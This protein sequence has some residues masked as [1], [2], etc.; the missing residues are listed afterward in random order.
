MQN[1]S[2]LPT[3]ASEIDQLRQ[4]NWPGLAAK[5]P[6]VANEL[7]IANILLDRGRKWSWPCSRGAL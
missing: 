1:S 5:L 7:P 3:V 4:R 2:D 6:T